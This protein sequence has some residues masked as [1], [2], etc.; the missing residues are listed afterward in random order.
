MIGDITQSF[1]N[2][3][4]PG[5]CIASSEKKISPQ[6]T[7]QVAHTV[8]PFDLHVLLADVATGCVF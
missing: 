1:V 7:L 8:N 3:S 2:D 5:S 4:V 6:E